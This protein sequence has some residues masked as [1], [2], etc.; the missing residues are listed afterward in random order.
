LNI[1]KDTSGI[2]ELNTKIIRNGYLM[3]IITEEM[4]YRK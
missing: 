2:I 1:K 4:N 3:K